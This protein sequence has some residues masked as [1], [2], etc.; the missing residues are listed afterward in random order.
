MCPGRPIWR[1]P[2]HHHRVASKTTR[3]AN[4]LEV[5]R[6][7][8]WITGQHEQNEG[9]DI[10]PR[11]WCA[12]QVWQGALCHVFLKCCHKPHPLWRLLK[13]CSP[14]IQW[15]LWNP[16]A[17]SYLQVRTIYWNSLTSRCRPMTEVKL[18]QI[19]LGGAIVLLPRG[20]LTLKWRLWTRHNQKMPCSTCPCPSSLEE[21]YTTHMPGAPCAT[22]V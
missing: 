7:R 19:R 11:N 22:Q 6:R 15:N 17:R 5:Q 9:P 3:E 1:W 21:Q 13:V 4:S 2:G 20:H 16:E 18:V 8:K 10:R 14:E 12:P